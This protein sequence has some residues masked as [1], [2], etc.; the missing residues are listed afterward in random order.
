MKIKHGLESKW[1]RVFFSNF[2][3][4][5]NFNFVWCDITRVFLLSFCVTSFF[6][7]IFI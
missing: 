5:G 2:K 1:S 3:N 7:V 4:C 6:L